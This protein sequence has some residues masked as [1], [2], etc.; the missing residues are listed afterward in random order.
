M[1]A[2]DP[3]IRSAGSW[4]RDNVRNSEDAGA[5]VAVRVFSAQSRIGSD[6]ET[7]GE[8]RNGV[9]LA[10]AVGYWQFR[11]IGGRCKKMSVEDGEVGEWGHWRVLGSGPRADGLFFFLPEGLRCVDGFGKREG[12][13]AATTMK[14]HAHVSLTSYPYNGNPRTKS[15][16]QGQRQDASILFSWI[17]HSPICCVGH[18]K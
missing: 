16:C 7:F 2:C 18:P 12:L 6:I 10:A 8:G 5:L 17:L 11:L 4:T 9:A 1:S 3:S 13:P 14:V 15:R